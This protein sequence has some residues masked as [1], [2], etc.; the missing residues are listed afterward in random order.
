MTAGYKVSLTGLM[1]AMA[2]AA[3]ACHSTNPAAPSALPT[4]AAASSFDL[5]GKVVGA[6]G[7]GLAG[8]EIVLS[9]DDEQRRAVTDEDGSFRVAGLDAGD[10]TATLNC[11]GYEGRAFEVVINGN[12]TINF[13]LI[14]Q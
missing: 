6:G 12:L 1:V 9:K 14:P 11:K 3:T 7:A 13:D 10:W 4:I 5:T 8:V 2:M